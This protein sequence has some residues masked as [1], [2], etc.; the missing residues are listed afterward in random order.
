MKIQ[1]KP[2]RRK[3][4]PSSQNQLN[5]GG[6][7][8]PNSIPRQRKQMRTGDSNKPSRIKEWKLETMAKTSHRKQ[9]TKEKVTWRYE[10]ENEIS[11]MDK[12]SLTRRKK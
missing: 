4:T 11:N 5:P 6:T 10:P 1:R 2:H 12:N 9:N 7:N 8:K 3:Q